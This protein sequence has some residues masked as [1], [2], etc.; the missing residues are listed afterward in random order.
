MWRYFHINRFFPGKLLRPRYTLLVHNSSYRFWIQE[1][2]GFREEIKGIQRGEPPFQGS[3]I[4]PPLHSQVPRNKYHT[5]PKVSWP[6]GSRVARVGPPQPATL[7]GP[8][9]HAWKCFLCRS[10]WCSR[11]RGHD[12]L[13]WLRHS[14]SPSW[15]IRE[16]VE[17]LVLVLPCRQ[18]WWLIAPLHPNLSACFA[19]PLVQARLQYLDRLRGCLCWCRKLGEDLDRRWYGTAQL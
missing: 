9:V 13:P 14:L 4:P 1:L 3:V 19:S 2:G 18:R 6:T 17:K 7:P 16:T 15:S 10:S 5:T 11:G 12:I 8:S